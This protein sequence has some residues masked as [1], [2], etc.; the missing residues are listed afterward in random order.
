M[1]VTAD[2][3]DDGEDVDTPGDGF[4]AAHAAELAAIRAIP[5]P[6]IRRAL[7]ILVVLLIFKGRVGR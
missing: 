3:Y 2:A 1:T 6:T 4:V 7:M 5:D